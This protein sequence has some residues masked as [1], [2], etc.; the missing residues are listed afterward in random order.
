MWNPGKEVE[1]WINS[2]VNNVTDSVQNEVDTMRNELYNNIFDLMS[3]LGQSIL[4]V[5]SILI[6][7][8]I[9]WACYAIMIQRESMNTIF[10]GEMKPIDSFYFTGC[11]YIIVAFLKKLLY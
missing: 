11:A 5:V 10:F 1:E 3:Y 2:K 6:I 7:I 9:V 8:Y 4:E